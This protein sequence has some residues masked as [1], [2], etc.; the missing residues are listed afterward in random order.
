MKR[1]ITVAI[2]TS[3]PFDFF[4]T[5]T[6]TKCNI[7]F[8]A[9][10]A[11]DLTDIYALSLGRCAPSGFV[12]VYQ[13]NP[14]RLCY[15]ILIHILIYMYLAFCVGGI[16]GKRVLYFHKVAKYST[17]MHIISYCRCEIPNNLCSN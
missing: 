10:L 8:I 1:V 6:Y 13:S 17:V 4:V 14:S 15:N 5:Y 11:Q 9:Q 2:A 7:N 3:E 12:R 16:K